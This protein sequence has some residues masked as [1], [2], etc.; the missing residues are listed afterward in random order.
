MSL[1][2]LCDSYMWKCHYCHDIM[3]NKRFENFWFTDAKRNCIGRIQRIKC[4]PSFPQPL[5]KNVITWQLQPLANP[6]RASRDSQGTQGETLR[7]PIPSSASGF[8]SA[9]AFISGLEIA[10]IR[11]NVMVKL[12]VIASEESETKDRADIAGI[13]QARRDRGCKPPATGTEQ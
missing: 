5:R 1:L 9:T 7:K 2:L 13:F 4:A 3:Q 8:G 10:A 12:S 6:G 11:A